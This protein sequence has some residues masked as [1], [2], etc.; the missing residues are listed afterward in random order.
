MA[1]CGSP[2][3]I[4]LKVR[5]SNPVPATILICSAFSFGEKAPALSGFGHRQNPCEITTELDVQFPV[6]RREDDGVN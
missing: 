1:P 4:N 3:R 6:D 2:H 5:G